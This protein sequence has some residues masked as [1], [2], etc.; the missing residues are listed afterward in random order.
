[1]VRLSR[2]IDCRAIRRTSP[3]RI[4]SSGEKSEVGVYTVKD[5]R[6]SAKSSCRAPIDFIRCERRIAFGERRKRIERSFNATRHGSVI[7]PDRYNRDRL[8]PVIIGTPAKRPM[9]LSLR[10]FDRKIV[11]AGIPAL[12]QPMFVKFP[13]SL[14]YE[15]TN[16]RNHRAI[17]RR[18]TPRQRLPS[19]AQSS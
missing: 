18:K 15:R 19:W 14:P 3:T 4:R 1:M 10:F 8:D 6:S 12:H 16:A 13:I 5:E 2:T 9:I 7:R 17:R 11:D